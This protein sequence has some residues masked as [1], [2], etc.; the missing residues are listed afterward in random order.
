MDYFSPARQTAAKAAVKARNMAN[1]IRNATACFV[2]F[3]KTNLFPTLEE[4]EH[5]QANYEHHLAKLKSIQAAKVPRAWVEG[6]DDG[7]D[8]SES[9]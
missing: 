3:A 6:M 8:R 4:L 5:E 9:Q 7:E 2:S 1:P